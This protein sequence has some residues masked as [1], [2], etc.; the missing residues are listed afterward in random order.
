MD[1]AEK[2]AV[3]LVEA[4]FDQV[5]FAGEPG[6]V[7]AFDLGALMR[8]NDRFAASVVQGGDERA[9]GKALGMLTQLAAAEVAAG[10]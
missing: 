10:D 6:V 8:W 7:L 1:K 2:G 9:V 3:Q 4:A 5:A